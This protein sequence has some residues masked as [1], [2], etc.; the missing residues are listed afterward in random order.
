MIS[1]TRGKCQIIQLR[2]WLLL[3]IQLP[4]LLSISQLNF[5]SQLSR[6]VT[7]LIHQRMMNVPGKMYDCYVIPRKNIKTKISVKA[8][9]GIGIPNIELSQKRVT[10]PFDEI[11]AVSIG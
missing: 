8:V 10:N 9:Y 6:H 11:S 4:D 7:N 1:N 3:C 2:D 5:R